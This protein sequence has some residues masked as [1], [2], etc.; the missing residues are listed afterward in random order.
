MAASWNMSKDSHLPISMT[1]DLLPK[2]S[3]LLFLWLQFPRMAF[4]V[5]FSLSLSLKEEAA[6]KK[7]KKNW[8]GR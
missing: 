4:L 2:G 3:V 7:R 8:K 6:K 1:Y 5:F